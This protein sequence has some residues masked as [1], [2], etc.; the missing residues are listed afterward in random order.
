LKVV[1]HARA[2]DAAMHGR[3]NE[4]GELA[5]DLLDDFDVDV[6]DLVLVE[7]SQRKVLMNVT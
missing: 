5:G 3:R 4:A 1:E 7:R 6:D 2:I